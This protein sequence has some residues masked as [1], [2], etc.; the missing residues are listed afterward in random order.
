MNRGI[1]I[2]VNANPAETTLSSDVGVPSTLFS[3]TSSP[4][5]VKTV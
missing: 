2:E 4:Y 3:Q 1:K 5:E